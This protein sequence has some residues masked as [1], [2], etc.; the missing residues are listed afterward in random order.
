MRM[1]R[2]RK[3]ELETGTLVETGCGLELPTKRARY[4]PP[5][6]LEQGA[7]PASLAAFVETLQKT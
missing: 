2:A 4:V 6:S 7:S 3:E 1:M 5:Q